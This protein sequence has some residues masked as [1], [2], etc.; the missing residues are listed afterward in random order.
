LYAGNFFVDRWLVQPSLDRLEL[1]ERTQHLRPK[2]MQVLVLLADRAGQVVSREELLHAVWQDVHISEEGLNHCIAEIRAA[3]GDNA[4]APTFVETVAKHGYRLVA[5]VRAWE[6]PAAPEPPIAKA[7]ASHVAVRPRPLVAWATTAGA[8]V[9]LVLAGAFGTNPRDSRPTDVPSVVLLADWTNRTGDPGFDGTLQQALAIRLAELPFIRILSRERVAFALQLMRQP[10][11]TPVAAA[12]AQHVCQRVGGDVVVSGGI[13]SLGK[14]FTIMLEAIQCGDAA[15]IAQTRVEANGRDDVLRAVDRAAVSLVQKLGRAFPSA[16]GSG[17]P[18]KEATT[19]NL[20]ALRAFELGDEALARK[21]VWEAISLFEHAAET[22]PAF[23][24]AHGAAATALAGIREWKHA[25][26][27]RD[28]AIAQ[29]KGLTDREQLYVTASHQLGHGSVGEA[30]TT[31]KTW[32]RIYPVD[33]V[34]LGWLAV[35]AL[36][37]GERA[38]ASAW[39]DAVPK[40]DSTSMAQSGL[41][42]VSLSMGRLGDAEAMARRVPDPGLLFVLA[43]LKQDEATMTRLA[44]DV[45]PGSFEEMDMRA[46]Q[47]QAAAAVGR[48][49]ESR[50]LVGEA[51]SIGLRLGLR[52]LTSQ[53]LATLAVWEAETGNGPLATELAGASLS[54]DDNPSTRAL[55]VLTFSRSGSAD[56]AESVLKR[57]NSAGTDVDP[58]VAAGAG[59]KLRAAL[60]LARGRPD[61]AI[62]ELEGLGSYEIGGVANLVAL[63]G[64]LAELCVFHLRGQALLALGQGA[65]AALEF[66][67]IIANRTVSPLSPYC[68]LASL[69][70]GRA[71]GQAGNRVAA[72]QAYDEFFSRWSEADPDV[73]VLI[74]ARREYRNLLEGASALL[75]R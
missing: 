5:T 45:A 32:S 43:F 55:A 70:L 46:R 11:G 31:L 75:Q 52:E 10:P 74:Q 50:R 39:V 40:V 36:N 53:I 3:F 64:D 68:A 51:E 62:R 12:V 19:A 23:A 63:R 48:F 41:A 33:R 42:A 22:D 13:A 73:A 59:R 27:H 69:N 66:Q 1:G 71:H 65:R 49:R 58:A 34:P 44:A 72:R 25:N 9:L 2:T 16:P 4:H 6:P 67:R 57:I 28:Q 30:E 35:S 29:L 38:R 61:Y 7:H 18:L 60:E 26:Q 14:N 15:P 17:R 37:R 20:E 54:V 21:S 56:R 47:A 24:L 8:F